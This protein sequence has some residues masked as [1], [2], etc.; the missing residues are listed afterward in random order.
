MQKKVK[1]LLNEKEAKITKRAYAFKGF[2]SSHNVKILNCFNPELQVKD[3]ESSIK[4]KLIDLLPELKGF[5]F[6]KILVLVFKNKV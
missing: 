2:S 6:V 3:I 4:S 1:I 5:T